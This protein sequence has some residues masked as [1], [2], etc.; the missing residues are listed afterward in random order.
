MT[1]IIDLS[2]FNSVD[3]AKLVR[4]VDGVMIRCGYRGYGS[5]KIVADAKCKTYVADC[6]KAGLPFGLYFM[7][8]AISTAEGREEADYTLDVA[9]ET[10]AVLP[11]FIDSEDGDGTSK[12]VRAD[13]LSKSMRTAVVKAFC[14]RILAAGK[15]GGVYASESWFM[16]RLDYPSLMDYKIWVAKYGR[17]NGKRNDDQSPRLIKYDMWQYTSNAT[18]AGISGR[19]DLSECYFDIKKDEPQASE[20]P[21][22]EQAKGQTYTVG[23]NY[24]LQANMYVRET[25]GGKKKKYSQLTSN[26]KKNAVRQITGAAVLKKGTVV[27]VKAVKK[28]GTATWVQIPSGWVCGVSETGK[29][30]VK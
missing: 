18:F 29:V 2:K 9:K 4:K 30:Y 21:K 24:T 12:V 15:D 26:A 17:N 19:Y 3:V 14:D 10:G 5:G 8:Q 25:A 11:L 23:R 20:P 13:A 1:T 27:T 7:S 16:D 28:L 22:T 6:K